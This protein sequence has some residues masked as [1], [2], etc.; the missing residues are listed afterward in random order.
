MMLVLQNEP[1]YIQNK[2]TPNTKRSV[3]F[4]LKPSD[5]FYAL[6]EKASPVKAR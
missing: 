3:A 2:M 1:I 6:V 5:A 4:F